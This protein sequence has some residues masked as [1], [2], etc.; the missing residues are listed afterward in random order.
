MKVLDP[1][2][3]VSTIHG[4]RYLSSHQGNALRL[5]WFMAIL[6]AFSTCDVIMMLNVKENA[7]HPISSV[8]SSVPI[9]SLPFPAVTI[10]SGLNN[11]YFDQENYDGLLERVLNYFTLDCSAAGWKDRSKPN[12]TEAED[13][14]KKSRVVRAHFQH[15]LEN[16]VYHHYDRVKK[17]I[18]EKSVGNEMGFRL[19]CDYTTIHAIMQ[20]HLRYIL[21]RNDTLQLEADLKRIL[22][23]NF[24][25]PFHE[26]QENVLEQVKEVFPDD[27]TIETCHNLVREVP[28]ATV[29]AFATFMVVM[30]NPYSITP[31]GTLLR[32]SLS[33][34]YKAL[35]LGDV[36]KSLLKFVSKFILKQTLDE[37]TERFVA[38]MIGGIDGCHISA[39]VRGTEAHERLFDIFAS[40]LTPMTKSDAIMKY[41]YTFAKQLATEMGLSHDI[42][43]PEDAVSL[44]S[45]VWHCKHSQ[46]IIDDC[47]D[48]SLAY[49]SAGASHTMNLGKWEDVFMQKEPI[50]NTLKDVDEP[51]SLNGLHE[52]T[53]YI[54]SPPIG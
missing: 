20:H 2:L 7:K 28:R 5:I 25:L 44:P 19:I 46:R 23:D 45:Q 38:C 51:L 34:K 31:L 24:L 14:M 39:T 27:T 52:I 35:L 42:L 9:S 22:L 49:T 6:C 21:R 37:D 10:S 11:A 30:G 26:M 12:L 18:G 54:Q 50:L 47:F 3:S 40:H 33:P 43:L 29:E 1:F 13:C 41:Y 4:L 16:G 15:A 36:Q 53:L 17:A 32:K 48:F 8:I